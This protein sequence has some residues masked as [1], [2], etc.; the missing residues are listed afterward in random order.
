MRTITDQHR[1]QL[2]INVWA[3]GQITQITLKPHQPLTHA[4]YGPTDEGW[5]GLAQTWEW[6]GGR[7][8]TR[9]CT[10]EGR[11]CDG[12]YRHDDDHIATVESMGDDRRPIWQRQGH[13]RVWDEFAE[14]AGY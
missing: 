8:I 9:Q 1:R 12:G 10:S 4:S 14:A 13:S 3:N 11:D 2:R 6:D 5:A 7:Y